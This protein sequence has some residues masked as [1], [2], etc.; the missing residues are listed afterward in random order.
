MVDENKKTENSIFKQV[1][2]RLSDIYSRRRI[3]NSSEYL[4][5][6]NK[7]NKVLESENRKTR[8]YDSSRMPGGIVYL[9]HN[10]P[11]VIIPDLHARQDF[12]LNIMF[13]KDSTGYSNIQKLQLDMLQIVRWSCFL[14]LSFI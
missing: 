14:I 11:S 2:Q 8:P 3:P 13:Y 4:N 10:V 5:I 9:K 7:V 12:F 1:K 6:L